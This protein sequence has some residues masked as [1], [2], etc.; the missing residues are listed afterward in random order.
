MF[1]YANVMTHVRYGLNGP[2]HMFKTSHK[3]E[4]HRD[5][6]QKSLTIAHSSPLTW[7]GCQGIQKLSENTEIMSRFQI[8]LVHEDRP[9]QTLCTSPVAE[10]TVDKMNKYKV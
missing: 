4:I 10:S 5:L 3:T 2:R 7:Q 1:L 9:V 8:T 6:G